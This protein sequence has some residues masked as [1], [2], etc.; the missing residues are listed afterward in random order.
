MKISKKTPF[1]GVMAALA[2]VLSFLETLLPPIVSAVPGI[3]LGL[4]NLIIILMLYKFSV[5]EAAYVS[6]VRLLAVTLLF[7]SV[8]TFIYSFVGAVFSLTVMAVL[9][10]L[11]WFS[12]VGVSVLGGVCHNLGQIIVAVIILQTKEIGYYFPVLAISGVIAG[13][14]I[15]L[16]AV[17]VSNRMDKIKIQ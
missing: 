17:L 4:P 1:L 2:I 9:K 5:K 11:E 8:M 12:K 16:C 15:G 10:R 7:G 14:L 3:K 6:A 13:T